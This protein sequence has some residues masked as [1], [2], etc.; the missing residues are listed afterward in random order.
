MTTSMFASFELK[1]SDIMVLGLAEIK[2]SMI[3]MLVSLVAATKRER[4]S[5]KMCHMP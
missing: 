2:E 5:F 3:D 1:G 4:W